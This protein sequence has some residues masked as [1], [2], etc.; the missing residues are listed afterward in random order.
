M[1]AETCL[2]K[3]PPTMYYEGQPFVIRQEHCLYCGKCY[4]NCPVQAVRKR[5]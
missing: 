2:K 3:L 1:D 4:E 5:G